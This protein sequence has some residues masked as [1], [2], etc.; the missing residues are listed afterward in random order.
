MSLFP[1]TTQL[2]PSALNMPPPWETTNLTKL[3]QELTQ[4]SKPS[5]SKFSN[6]YATSRCANSKKLNIKAKQQ[7]SKTIFTSGRKMIVT[8]GSL[9]AIRHFSVTRVHTRATPLC[10]IDQPVTYKGKPLFRDSNSWVLMTSSDQVSCTPDQEPIHNVNGVF[11]GQKSKKV[12]EEAKGLRKISNCITK[13]YSEG[14]NIFADADQFIAHHRPI[15]FHHA[16]SERT[17]SPKQTQA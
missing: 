16:M 12:F 2:Y 9:F 15:M 4:L 13:I 8:R 7:P 10:Y 6:K 1:T 17:S 3:L 11:K 14:T 5:P